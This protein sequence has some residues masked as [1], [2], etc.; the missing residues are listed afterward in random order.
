M[1]KIASMYM[2]TN[3]ATWIGWQTPEKKGRKKRPFY[4][5]QSVQDR[6]KS[7]ISAEH[8]LI[9]LVMLSLLSVLST[10]ESSISSPLAAPVN[11]KEM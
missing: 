1:Q 4:I 11:L 10:Q 5:G 7:L 6:P 8:Y 3:R 9:V 2:D